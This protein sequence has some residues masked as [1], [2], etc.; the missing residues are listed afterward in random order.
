MRFSNNDVQ[1]M[2]PTVVS[3]RL[4]SNA[5]APMLIAFQLQMAYFKTTEKYWLF[6]TENVLIT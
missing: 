1:C 5:A 4:P 3:M 6:G 2:T